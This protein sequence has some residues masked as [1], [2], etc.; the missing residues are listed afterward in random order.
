MGRALWRGGIWKETQ[1]TEQMNH[2]PTG[3]AEGR[4]CRLCGAQKRRGGVGGEDKGKDHSVLV[5]G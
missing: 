3:E 5:N 4:T 2:M 1:G